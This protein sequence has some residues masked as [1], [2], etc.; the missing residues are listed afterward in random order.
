MKSCELCFES[1]DSVLTSEVLIL[2]NKNYIKYE[3]YALGE[4]TS[5]EYITQVG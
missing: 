3:F 4:K 5:H 1:V 2:Y